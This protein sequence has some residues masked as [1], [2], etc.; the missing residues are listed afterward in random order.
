MVVDALQRLIALEGDYSE[1]AKSAWEQLQNLYEQRPAT[2]AVLRLEDVYR[3]LGRY[4]EGLLSGEQLQD[5][6]EF[7]EMNDYVEYER[8]RE[9]IIADVLFR[10]SSPEINEPISSAVATRMR[11]SLTAASVVAGAACL[12]WGCRRIVALQHEL[13]AVPQDILDPIR[14]VESELD[15]IPDEVDAPRWEAEAFKKKLRERDDYLT[16]VR[17]GLI[18]CFQKLSA[19]LESGPQT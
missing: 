5:W 8:G 15:D 16:R 17:P 9:E 19:H 4:E 2:V 14:A 13:G 7:L 12:L 18:E 1:L 11:A 3:A 6:S 10:L